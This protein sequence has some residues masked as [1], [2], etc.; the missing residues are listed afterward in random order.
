[1]NFN[2]NINKDDQNTNYYLYCWDL[3]GSIPYKTII[4]TTYLTDPFLKKISKYDSWENKLSEI[5]PDEEDTI[6]NERVLL[7]IN[8]TVFISYL[9]IDKLIET[10]I[11]SEVVIYSKSK[12]DDNIVNSIISDLDTCIGDFYDEESTNE[13]NRLNTITIGSNGLEIEP[14]NL[15]LDSENIDSYYNR[16]TMKSINKSIKSMK[17]LE[18]GLLILSGERGTGKTSIIKYLSESI[19]RTFIFISNNFIDQTINNPD[20]R[21][22]LRRYSKPVLILDDCEMLFNDMFNKSNMVT[23]N[24]MQIIDGP[25]YKDV[26]VVTIFNVNDENEIDR[27]LIDSNNL[28]DIVEFNFLDKDESNELSLHIKSNK[29]YKSDVKL[30]DVLKKKK[31]EEKTPIGF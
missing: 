17:K 12:D 10:S 2:I 7:K 3:F 13:S 9:I 19:D 8:E 31:L 20:F 11:V 27:T 24:L 4:H 15:N 30:I 16:L 22:F 28:I 23:N 14:I 26:T 18:R 29:K 21:R 25:V 1:M 6:I 5:I